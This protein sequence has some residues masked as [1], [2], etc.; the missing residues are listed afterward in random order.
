MHYSELIDAIFMLYLYN[1]IRKAYQNVYPDRYAMILSMFT[2][3]SI[4]MQ[5]LNCILCHRLSENEY[6]MYHVI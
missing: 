4:F 5:K 3:S 6:I 1:F 2:V